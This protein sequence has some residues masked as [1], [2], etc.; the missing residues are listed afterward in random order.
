MKPTNTK[1]LLLGSI[2]Q[3]VFTFSAQAQAVF[4]DVDP[5]FVTV[6][7]FAKSYEINAS[8]L[9]FQPT[10]SS[11]DYAILT[12]P[13]PL[14]TP[15]WR[16]KTVKPGYDANFNIGLAYAIDNTA[17]DLQLSWT[18]TDFSD[19]RS[20]TASAV[21]PTQF[22]GPFYE[23]GPDAG[24]IRQGR[25]RAKFRYD[26]VNLD[27]GQ[28]VDY[29]RRFQ[30]RFFAGLNYL[31]LKQS[32][33]TSF[34]IVGD[35]NFSFTS[36]NISEFNGVGPRLGIAGTYELCYGFGLTAQLAGTAS[37]GRVKTRMNFNST[38]TALIVLG[39]NP[40]QQAITADHIA[41]IV[42]GGDAK[43]GV[44]YFHPF[45]RDY[46]LGLEAGYQV[47]SYMDPIEDVYPTSLVTNPATPLQSGTIAVNTMGESQ[48]NFGV[49]GP[50]FKAA[51]KF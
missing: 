22:T 28:F 1:Y 7:R 16:I 48:S 35:P 11:L 50:Y 27:A 42:P 45:G 9:Y 24:T 30:T 31:H 25:G 2:L 26:V 13:L 40:N 18:H 23:I 34:S 10:S 12:N 17:N 33:K 3:T 41:R 15:Q 32:L 36:E 5:L 38:S 37:V 51:F 4:A 44:T 8:L 20:V 49:S 6:P 21:N 46:L 43:L 14:P 39:A 19:S 47:T 29:G